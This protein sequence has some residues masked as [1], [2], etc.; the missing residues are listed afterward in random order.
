MGDPPPSSDALLSAPEVR[1]FK[2]D[3]RSRVWCVEVAGSRWVL[4]RFEYSRIRQRLGWLLGLHPAQRE[5][6][7]NRR[8]AAGGIAVAPIH[9]YGIT[10]GRGWLVTPYLGASVHDLLWSN[11]FAGPRDRRHVI[12][13]ASGLTASLLRKGLYNRDHK[14]S[15][16]I[17][18]AGGKA[19][20]IDVGAVRR[21]RGRGGLVSMLARLDQSAVKAG[22]SRPDRLRFLRLLGRECRSCTDWRGIVR[23]AHA[24]RH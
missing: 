21:L 13:A 23:D 3:H 20:L 12:V 10:G 17:M 2:S 7:M 5:L 15:N 11:P 8:L 14:A 16:L 18:D 19:W 24:I 1:V 22:A 6:R 9:A 4:K